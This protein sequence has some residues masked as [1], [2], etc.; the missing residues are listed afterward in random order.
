[1]ET[2]PII[3]AAMPLAG[4]YGSDCAKFVSVVHHK[5][6]SPQIGYLS[7]YALVKRPAKAVIAGVD[8]E[9][10]FLHN[11]RR[12]RYGR[13]VNVGDIIV[14]SPAPFH[15]AGLIGEDKNQN[16]RL[17][18]YDYVLHTGGK[19]PVYQPLY[20]TVLSKPNKNLRIVM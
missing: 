2:C 18:K 1:M 16:G 14:V 4:W 17:D 20:K 19:A 3:T 5:T 10:Y 12:I 6:V 7:T 13:E 8:K 15:H 11:N 9:G